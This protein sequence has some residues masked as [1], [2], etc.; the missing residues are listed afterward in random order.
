MR[1]V[2]RIARVPTGFV[3]SFSSIDLDFRIHPFLIQNSSFLSKE[4]LV[5]EHKNLQFFICTHVAHD[6]LTAPAEFTIF[7]AKFLVFDTQFL[8]FKC[9]IHHFDALFDRRV[10]RSHSTA[11]HSTATESAGEHSVRMSTMRFRSR[12]G[13]EKGLKSA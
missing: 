6:E 4:F 11:Q 8:V 5:F 7:N 3:P 1:I 9:K 2:V 10:C 12:N 13:L